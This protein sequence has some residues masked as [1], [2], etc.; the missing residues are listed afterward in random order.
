MKP[1]LLLVPAIAAS[2]LAPSA[3]ADVIL[4]IE[5]PRLNVGQYHRPYVASWIEGPENEHVADLVV[6]YDDDM[7]NDQGATWLKDL[8]Q[9]WRKSG[10]SAKLPIDGVT[11]AT[12]PVGHHSVEIPE[13]KVKLDPLAS[14]EYTLV[15]EAAREVGG[16]EIVRIPFKWDGNAPVE[17][18]DSGKTELGK[19]Q[20]QILKA[21]PE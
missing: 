9:W 1:H 18:S 17:V 16:R 8:R 19:I 3:S 2:A 5:V 11:G 12:R 21:K 6:W 10:R 4:S 13:S 15:V 20:F 14:G 7:Q